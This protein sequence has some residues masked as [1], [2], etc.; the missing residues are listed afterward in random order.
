MLGALVA[1]GELERV[2]RGLYRRASV[3][4][5]HLN[6]A[7]VA[8]VAPNGV[9]RLLSTL[10][11]YGLTTMTP[12]DVYLAIPRKARPPHRGNN[13]S[14][15]DPLGAVDLGFDEVGVVVAGAVD[16]RRD[17]VGVHLAIGIGA[18]EP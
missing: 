12:S 17:R 3:W 11:Y 6:L 10:A 2:R 9:I 13:S 4:F 1:A 16:R 5:E 7:D 15:R 8:A 14:R 18:E